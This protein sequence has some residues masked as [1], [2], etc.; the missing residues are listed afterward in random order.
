MAEKFKV[1]KEICISCGTCIVACPKGA[2]WDKDDK[3]QITDSEEIEKCGGKATC[4]Y[5]A[6]KEASIKED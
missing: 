2:V 5:G 3:A 1:E 6:I 4:P